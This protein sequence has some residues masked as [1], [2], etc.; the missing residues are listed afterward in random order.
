M[1]KKCTSLLKIT[2]RLITVSISV[3]NE[4]WL[5]LRSRG[6]I[7]AALHLEFFVKGQAERAADLEDFFNEATSDN[8]RLEILRKYHVRWI[9]LNS[10]KLPPR[11]VET[12]MVPAGVI[13]SVD[14][15]TL[16]DAEV[17]AR[18]LPSQ[19]ASDKATANPSRPQP[20]IVP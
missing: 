9:V 1:S 15:L 5:K 12:L 20:A 7:V 6:R 16:L 13:A 11:V 8:R 19:A 18:H 14:T 3:N 10:A 2:A 17:W 4:M